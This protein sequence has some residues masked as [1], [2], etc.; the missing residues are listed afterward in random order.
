MESLVAVFGWSLLPV[1]DRIEKVIIKM[2]QQHKYDVSLGSHCWHEWRFLSVNVCFSMFATSSM[3]SEKHK[4]SSS[5]QNF[6][7]GVFCQWSY[8]QKVV[9]STY[10]YLREKACENVTVSIYSMIKFLLCWHPLMLGHHDSN[11]NESN[12]SSIV[13]NDVTGRSVTSTSTFYCVFLSLITI[14]IHSSSQPLRKLHGM[15]YNKMHYGY[16]AWL[17]V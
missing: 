14:C 16:S 4:M 17:I 6:V 11:K 13:N 2:C 9:G 12:I 10:L 5:A 3:C 8:A 15:G 7:D 1:R